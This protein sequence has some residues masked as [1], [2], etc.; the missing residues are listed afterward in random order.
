[1]KGYRAYFGKG[2]IFV[3]RIEIPRFTMQFKPD[4]DGNFQTRLLDDGELNEFVA[5]F[6]EGASL[7]VEFWKVEAGKAA[8]SFL[9]GG[10]FCVSSSVIF[11]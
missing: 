10:D 1:M 4:A 7:L 11:F 2:G 6:G 8:A 3:H 9:N 5:E